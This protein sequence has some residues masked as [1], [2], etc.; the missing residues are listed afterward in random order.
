MKGRIMK[1]IIIAAALLLIPQISVAMEEGLSKKE[2]NQRFYDLMSDYNNEKISY[3]EYKEGMQKIIDLIDEV[4]D[5]YHNPLTNA[6]YN[7][8]YSFAKLLLDRGASPVFRGINQMDAYDN[9][10][11]RNSI[12]Y[13]NPDAVAAFKEL[14]DSYL[15]QGE[16]HTPY[17]L[18]GMNSAYVTDREL[19]EFRRA[20]GLED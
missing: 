4:Q 8:D 11:L 18:A 3:N 16:Q 20:R 10:R 5:H 12:V 6:V 7:S 13:S 15:K 9:L 17:P 14:L 2:A 1:K 19:M